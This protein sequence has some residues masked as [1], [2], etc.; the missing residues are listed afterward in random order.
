M[1]ARDL[2]ST[3]LVDGLSATQLLEGLGRV[4]RWLLVTDAQ[5]RILWMSEGVSS[6]LGGDALAIGADARDFLP[7]LPRPEQVFALRKQ[8][9]GRGHAANLPLEL[10]SREGG[11]VPVQVS[12]LK[13]ETLER[14][15]PLLVAI[16]RP[17]SPERDARGP[18]GLERS[19]VDRAP[20]GIVTLD[21][22]GFVVYANA[23]AG[24]LCARDP[25]EMRGDPAALLFGRGAAEAL[26]IA[27]A[28]GGCE[29]EECCVSLSRP[30]GSE[31]PVSVTV[32]A[33]SGPAQEA[34]GKAL[35]IRDVSRGQ[36][37]E[38]DLARTNE[39]LE[40]CVTSLAHDLRSPLVALLGFSRL[41]RQEYASLL[42]QTGR[43]FID[44]IEQAG[45]TMESLVH[46]ML[47]L[48]RIGQ[49]GEHLVMV[50]PRGVF[51]QLRAE[52]KP[53]LDEGGIELH[54]EESSPP[55]VYTDRTRL[56]QLL[57][58]LIGNAIDHM[59]EPES[60]R[61]EVSVRDDD[62]GHHISVRDNGR[63]IPP[64]QIRRVFEAFHSVPREGRRGTGMGLAIVKRIAETHG[65]RAWVESA[66]GEGATFHV[67]LPRR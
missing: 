51:A 5:R 25:D 49:S 65:G 56:Y 28:V 29:S 9:R 21:G 55:L 30:D 35:F 33:L 17:V 4:Y 62:E 13:V 42:D 38:A 6:L 58:N 37:R 23:A 44:R 59:G 11:M 66:L 41:L 61:I 2:A 22:D 31:I 47:E 57:S 16:A 48:S 60:P 63:G 8:L 18:E 67:V 27:S 64:D 46:D 50:D 43:H 32:T 20:D 19:L 39:E 1:T 36:R 14:G 45:R 34:A 15:A 26:R 7:R 3:Q 53:R 54:L 24:R 10:P 52:L 40:H 12:L